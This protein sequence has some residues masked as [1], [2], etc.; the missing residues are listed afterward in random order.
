MKAPLQ[1]LLELLK[2]VLEAQL[3]TLYFLGSKLIELWNSLLLITALGG[4]WVAIF[5]SFFFATVL[6]L[7]L[8]FLKSNLKI[9]II[10]F[11]LVVLLLLLLARF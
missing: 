4:F 8:K 5:V 2:G 9:L 3:S 10:L 1:I 6:V 7:A 11:L